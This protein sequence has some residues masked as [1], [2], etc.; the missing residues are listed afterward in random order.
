MK[1][2]TGRESSMSSPRTVEDVALGQDAG[3]TRRSPHQQGVAAVGAH[4]ASASR[5]GVP[6]VTE[7]GARFAMTRAF[8]LRSSMRVSRAV[9]LSMLLV[10]AVAS[11]A[12]GLSSD[13]SARG[14]GPG[15]YSWQFGT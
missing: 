15:F 2:S 14:N 7:P 9:V 6:S 1:S 3:Q 12:V 5:S 10:L 4:L 8:S 11:T 13:G